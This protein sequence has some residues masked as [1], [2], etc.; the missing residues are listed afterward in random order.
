MIAV[1]YRSD[2]KEVQSDAQLATL[3]GEGAQDSPF[4]RL[5]WW[6]GLEAHC[7]IVPLLAVARDGDSLAVLPLKANG[8]HLE[9]LS[10]WYSFRARPVVTRG[11]DALPLLTA[12]A[13]DIASRTGR[14]ILSG[15]PDEDRSATLLTQ[16]FRSAGW[17][18]FAE[19][20]GRNHV[21]PVA[22]RSYVQYIS[23][24][25]GPLRTALKRKAEKLRTVIHTRFDSEAWNSYEAIYRQSWKPAEGSP[26]FLRQFAR[27]EGDAGRLRL[28]L[29]FAGD[30]AVAA[31]LWTVEGGTAFIHKLAHLEE[32]KQLSPGTVLSAA[33]FEHVIDRDR[34]ALVDFGTGNDAYKLHWMESVRLRHR[35]DMFRPE[36]PGNWPAIA[37]TAL[38]RLAMRLKHG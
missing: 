20:C 14:I 24:R 29:A 32:A 23:T 2:L 11:A 27:A 15:V 21:L 25:P 38:S 13:R 34:V 19:A 36:R 17:T 22:G 16:A 26:D 4:D 33:L 28:G 8:R 31:Q 18:V 9:A 35:L 30:R 6:Q 10:N 12:I 1:E 5:A 7:G 3:L 37:R